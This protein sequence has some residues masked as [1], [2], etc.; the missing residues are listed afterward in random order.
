MTVRIRN[1]TSHSAYTI[2]DF[3]HVLVC[4]E[5]VFCPK[6]T[7]VSTTYNLH[8]GGEK[9]FC[10]EEILCSD[11]TYFLQNSSLL[12]VCLLNPTPPPSPHCFCPSR[13]GFLWFPGSTWL[14]A[15]GLQEANCL[16][17]SFLKKG[18]EVVS[19]CKFTPTRGAGW[20]LHTGALMQFGLAA[21]APF[22]QA[23]R[24]P[25]R[26]CTHL[27]FDLF[28]TSHFNLTPAV[29]QNWSHHAWVEG[30]Q[31]NQCSLPRMT[32]SISLSQCDKQV[33]FHYLIF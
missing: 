30:L 29:P 18:L 4:I 24:C 23:Q 11:V 19:Q 14:T 32:W 22:S 3:S 2:F 16:S 31:A 26:P 6:N 25:L 13:P 15:S 27:T 10:R 7:I 12:S 5:N 17:F 21:S 33:S 1:I 9:T 8:H 28:W 20:F